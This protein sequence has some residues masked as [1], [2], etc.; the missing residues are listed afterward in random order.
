M[1]PSVFADT[2]KR[3]SADAKLGF[4][5]ET[6][7][8]EDSRLYVEST[9]DESAHTQELKRINLSGGLDAWKE[10]F[11]IY[12]PSII[13]IN[14][15]WNS[16]K[17]KRPTKSTWRDWM[18]A[19]FD[20]VN[21]YRD[22]VMKYDLEPKYGWANGSRTEVFTS[23]SMDGDAGDF[24][25]T[26]KKVAEALEKLLHTTVKVNNTNIQDWRVVKDDS[27]DGDSSGVGIEIVSPPLP[28]N[29]AL[30][31]LKSCFKFMDENHLETND[32]TGLHINLSIPDLKEKLD[33]LKLILFMGEEHILKSYSREMNRY[34]K[35]HVDGILDIIG[36]KGQLPKSGELI[37]AARSALQSSD[38]Y[39]TVN[40]GKLNHGYLEFRAAGNTNYHHKYNKVIDDIGRFLTILELACDP[41]A[42]RQ[43]Y[44]KKVAK[45][46]D[47]ALT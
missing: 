45:L 28:I 33:P 5:L 2:I 23:T 10:Y 41:N 6:W 34:T 37:N 7:V 18:L 25:Q 38:K 31:A 46:F 1:K 15:D 43:E 17:A 20:P 12:G 9:S 29:D 27:I 21:G 39:K 11:N 35:K 44:L 14:D 32:T 22:F 40:L 8:T 4:E 42:E 36:R 13:K 26:A 24:L 19:S 3:L 16:F 30:D 47:K